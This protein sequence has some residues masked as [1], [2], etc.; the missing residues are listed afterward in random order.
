MYIFFIIYFFF[1]IVDNVVVVVILNADT[2]KHFK[3]LHAVKS[4]KSAVAGGIK[5]V[6]QHRKCIN[7]ICT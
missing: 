5:S 6:R 1:F 2:F 4:V 7:V 3:Y